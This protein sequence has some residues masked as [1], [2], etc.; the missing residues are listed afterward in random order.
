MT[1]YEL[2]RLNRYI[3]FYDCDYKKRLRLSSILKYAAEIAG[4]DYTQKGFSHKYL[5]DNQMVFLLSRVSLKIEEYPLHSQDLTYETWECGKKGALF[6]RGVDFISENKTKISYQSGW[7]LANPITR[8]ML[9]PSAFNQ[10][11]PQ[12]MDRTITAPSLDKIVAKN[13]LKIDE[14]KVRY[15][16][17]DPNGHIYNAVYADICD[18][19][20]S[21]EDF[22]RDIDTFKI[23]YISEAGMGEKL[24]LYQQKEGNSIIVVGKSIEKTCF[25]AEYIFK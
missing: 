13:L 5:W 21:K 25:E 4:Y 3:P 2:C 18:D 24:C 10:D 7:V 12:I 11:M 9:R 20:L 6:L 1:E 22:E 23:N 8:K 19:I 17:I 14:H 16:D 15:S